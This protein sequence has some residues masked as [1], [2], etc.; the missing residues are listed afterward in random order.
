MPILKLFFLYDELE[1]LPVP[2]V[3]S[4]DCA[5]KLAAAAIYIHLQKKA[6]PPAAS[7]SSG[8]DAQ[9]AAITAF[10]FAPPIALRKHYEFLKG[11]AKKELNVSQSIHE[12]YQVPLILNT[13]STAQDVFTKPMS[14]L[15]GAVA[16]CDDTGDE[17]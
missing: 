10:K 5:R 15:V 14:D 17:R 9:N 11:L 16:I 7:D 3:K 12:D 2:D 13:Y 1:P 4:K 6:Q 8:S